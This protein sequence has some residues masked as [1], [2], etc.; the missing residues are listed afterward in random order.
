MTRLCLTVLP[1]VLFLSAGASAADGVC[2]P[3]QEQAALLRSKPHMLEAYRGL[4]ERS[5]GREC[6][7][8]AC[9]AQEDGDQPGARELFEKG[10]R[11][12]NREACLALGDLEFK[13]GDKA[14]AVK[15]FRAACRQLSREACVRLKDDAVEPLTEALDSKEVTKRATAVS[16]LANLG[17]GVKGVV[18]ALIDALDDD[19]V[20]VSAQA[21]RA[22][23]KLGPPAKAAVPAL[24]ELLVR[25]RDKSFASA[26][27]RGIGR[28]AVPAL[29]KLA[30]EGSQP[31][32]VIAAAKK[33][34]KEIETAK[35]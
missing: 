11:A 35:R 10:C 15:H 27:L 23:G 9:A 6:L 12:E 32:N 19:N 29:E 24:V 26:G 17:A 30:A 21:A 4:C 34:I 25:S 31:E 5:Y 20:S 33:L 7:L 18:P 14:R 2:P 16:M 28:D 1:L 3:L 8:L 22:L 13:E